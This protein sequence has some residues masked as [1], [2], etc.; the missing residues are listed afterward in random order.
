MIEGWSAGGKDWND[1]GVLESGFLGRVSSL[2]RPWGEGGGGRE[3]LLR[4]SAG[5]IARSRYFWRVSG[6]AL[7]R[8]G[9]CQEVS[10]FHGVYLEV[11]SHALGCTPRGQTDRRLVTRRSRCA[12]LGNALNLNHLQRASGL[13]CGRPRSLGAGEREKLSS[14]F[15]PR[16]AVAQW[17]QFRGDSRLQ[18]PPRRYQKAALRSVGPC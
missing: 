7:S 11:G 5:G 12:V 9:G 13:E 3:R 4:G 1:C 8:R 6:N 18:D 15:P 17:A 2:L 14:S 10:T 16:A